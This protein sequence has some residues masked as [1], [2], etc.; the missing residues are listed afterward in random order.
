VTDKG[1]SDDDDH[2][3]ITHSVT[4]TQGALAL[5]DTNCILLFFGGVLTKSS[6][7]VTNI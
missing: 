3:V 6:Y 2:D 1:L 4:S 7:D 5:R